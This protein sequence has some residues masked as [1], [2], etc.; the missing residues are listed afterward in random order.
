[1]SAYGEQAIKELLANTA[2]ADMEHLNW[3]LSEYQYEDL[4]LAQI[5]SI[6]ER[7][8]LHF[9]ASQGLEPINILL[10]IL[11]DEEA[12]NIISELAQ[13]M[14]LERLEQAVNR[15]KRVI[16]QQKGELLEVDLRLPALFLGFKDEPYDLDAYL[17]DILQI[18][19][20]TEVR[21]LLMSRI[22]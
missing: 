15:V 4:W 16:Q 12:K 9:R 1:M 6:N 7:A 2:Q 8:S 22:S 3:L 14:S 17:A 5:V 13:D 18:L 10:F 11:R 20:P 19:R 21:R